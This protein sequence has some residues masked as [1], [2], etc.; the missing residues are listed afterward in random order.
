[1][2][3]LALAID[4][5]AFGKGRPTGT[6]PVKPLTDNLSPSMSG[7]N[8]GAVPLRD[9]RA[10]DGVDEVDQ[11]DGVDGAHGPLGPLGPFGPFGP[12]RRLQRK[13]FWRNR[14]SAKGLDKAPGLC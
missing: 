8:L 13:P 14:P 7:C 6:F 2:P 10:V 4:E 9:T 12:L 11:V 5:A 3:N 1:M